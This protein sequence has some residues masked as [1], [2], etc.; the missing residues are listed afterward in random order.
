MAEPSQSP[1]VIAGPQKLNK[2]SH[3]GME[4]IMDSL[5]KTLHEKK[6]MS[7]LHLVCNPESLSQTAE[8]RQS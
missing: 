6:E 7:A 8:D 2:K 5:S 1:E 3:F 4:A